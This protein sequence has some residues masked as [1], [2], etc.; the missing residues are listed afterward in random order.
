MKIVADENM[1][2]LEPLF[3]SLGSIT[4]LPGRDIGPEQVAD[5]DALLV[6][7]VTKVDEAL[8]RA[9]PKLRFV[10]TATIGTDHLDTAALARR[11]IPWSNAPGCNAEAVGEY[12]LTA[13][14]LLAQRQ[15]VELSQR[16]VGVVGLGNTGS[17]VARRL[18]ALGI[19]VLCCDPP[20]AAQRAAGT[21]H[22]LDTLLAEC[23]VITLHVPLI[24]EG[25][26][27]TV[28]LLDEARLGMLKS[29]AWLV[30]ACRGEVIDNPALVR[31]KRKRPDLKLVLDVWANEPHPLADLVALAEIA[32]AH[33][34]GYSREG[35]IRGSQMLH[36][37]LM[38]QKQQPQQT[39]ALASLL[40]DSP[41]PAQQIESKLDQTELLSL[42]SGVYDLAAEDRLF[43]AALPDGF[44]R[45]RKANLARREFSAQTLYI[46]DPSQAKRLAQL[47]FTVKEKSEDGV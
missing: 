10:G 33:I 29:G 32:T 5:A 42:M 24:T 26:G 14:L 41:L 30:N 43:R 6:R 17:A 40:P 47:G 15:G 44:D 25:Q 9:A 1:A 21:W 11:G 7:S 12:V 20:K 27:A 23:D 8:L 38:Q 35:K 45:R 16:R 34:A 2:A 18:Q 22:E 36:R 46:A 19:E 37:A 4:S 13:L 31:V 39:P 3:A 28:N